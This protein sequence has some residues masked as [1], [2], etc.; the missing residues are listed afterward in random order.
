MRRSSRHAAFMS[1]FRQILTFVTAAT[2]VAHGMFGCCWLGAPSFGPR[3]RA[4]TPAPSP[5]VDCCEHC[6]HTHE[7]GCPHD[8]P[9]KLRCRGVCV[10]VAP[11]K[12]QLDAPQID[13]L[14]EFAAVAVL[15]T[16]DP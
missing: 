1:M 9:C 8:G 14:L 7:K 13:L 11:Q 10:Y 6:C 3:D 2:F 5:A 15:Q 16:G 4:I 12:S